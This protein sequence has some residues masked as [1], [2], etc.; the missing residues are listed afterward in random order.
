MRAMTSGDADESLSRR[1]FL[2]AVTGGAAIAAGAG[3]TAAQSGT[4]TNGNRTTT[5]G[6]EGGNGTDSDGGAAPGPTQE[7]TV[8]P[9]GELVFDP[10]EL[11]ITPGT[12]VRW[13]WDSNNHN[14]VVDEQPEGAG[15]EGTEG[16]PGTTYNTGHTYTHTFETTGTYEYACEPHRS[17]GM[18]GTVIVSEDAGGGGGGPQLP[19]S[20]KTLGVAL[21][22][23][24]LSTLS[25]AYFFVKYGGDYDVPE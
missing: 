24:M 13:V 8:G 6:G 5:A 15:W 10:D 19:S 17:A 25:F 12:T 18:L 22:A 4:A 1:G 16:G 23:A 3:A 20:A 9:G 21:V 11:E 2:T 7:V 14:I